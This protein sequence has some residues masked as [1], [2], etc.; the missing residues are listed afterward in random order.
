MNIEILLRLIWSAL[1]VLLLIGAVLMRWFYRRLEEH[2]R[3]EWL[4]LGSPTL[5]LNASMSNQRS[6]SRFLWSG[7]YRRLG[8][9]TLDRLAL[10]ARIFGGLSVVLFL[11]GAALVLAGL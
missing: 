6:V 3:D 10:A 2:H 5:I 7:A 4:S 11:L 1:M 9:P 8:D